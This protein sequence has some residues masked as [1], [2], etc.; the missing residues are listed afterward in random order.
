MKHGNGKM[1][2]ASG[3]YFEGEWKNNK[4]NG[5]GTMYWLT[6]NEKYFLKLNLKPS[7]RYTGNWVDNF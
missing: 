1:T 3:N 2:Y 4:R 5:N 6:S 7:Y